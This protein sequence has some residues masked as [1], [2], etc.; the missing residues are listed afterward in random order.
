MNH[1]KE[2]RNA[3][4]EIVKERERQLQSCVEEC[5]TKI[6]QASQVCDFE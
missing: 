4:M 5:N 6:N 2:Y 1:A 3:S